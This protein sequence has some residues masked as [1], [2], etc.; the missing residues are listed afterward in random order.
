MVG[1]TV[2]LLLECEHVQ[3]EYVLTYCDM[4]CSSYH[5]KGAHVLGGGDKGDPAEWQQ[6]RPGLSF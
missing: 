5:C 6:Q 3:Y 2:S 4:V 1:S